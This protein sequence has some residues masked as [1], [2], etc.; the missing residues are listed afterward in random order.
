MLR[1]L[2]GILGVALLLMVLRDAF[3][4]VILPRRIRRAFRLTAIFYRASWSL[5]RAVARRLRGG[6]RES[7]LGWFGPLSLLVLLALWAVS[8]IFAFALL[9][10]AGGSSLH[11]EGHTARFLDDLYI[12]STNFV[13]LGLGDVAPADT[14]ARVLT[15]SEA[16][17]GFAFLAIIIGYLPVIYQTFSRRELMI[18]L[19]DARAGS[20][21]AAVELLRRQRG[22]ADHADLTR[23]LIDWERWSAELLESHISYPVLAYFRS[24]H[25]NQ[26]WLSAVTMVLDTSALIMLTCEGWCVRQAELTFAMARHAV[27][28]LSQVF[29]VREPRDMVDRLPPPAFA[30]LKTQLAQIGFVLSEPADLKLAELRGRYEPYVVALSRQLGLV[31]PQFVR[32]LGAGHDNWEGAP[33]KE[34]AGSTMTQH[35]EVPQRWP[36]LSPLEPPDDPNKP[37]ANG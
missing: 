18:S 35:F 30:Q 29:R 22:D 15:A 5:W 32:P 13:T 36:T 37:S 26:S 19:L 24:Q 34:H 27:V 4:T 33:W 7:T 28:D 16:G 6:F 1:L 11:V 31:L 8:I 21:P 20:P 17:M 3:E 25:G 9:Q 10:W 14:Y 2:V 12:S 23:W